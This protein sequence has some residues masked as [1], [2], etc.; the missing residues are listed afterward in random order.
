MKLKLNPEKFKS[1][2]FFTTAFAAYD[3]KYLS[4]GAMDASIV[5]IGGKKRTVNYYQ[6]AGTSPVTKTV[7]VSGNYPTSSGS[8]SGLVKDPLSASSTGALVDGTKSGSL[9]SCAAGYAWDFAS[10]SCLTTTVIA[11]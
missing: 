4:V 8:V 9:P 10:S 11:I 7:S 1:A 3:P 5:S 2:S 6:V